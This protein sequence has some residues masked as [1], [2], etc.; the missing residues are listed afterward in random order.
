MAL[1]LLENIE[2][3]MAYPV[4]FN[5]E[6]FKSLPT[7]AQRVKYCREKLGQQLGAGTSRRVYPIDDEKV[8]KLAFNKKGVAQNEAECDWFLQKIGLCAKVYDYDENYLWIEMQKAR[9]AKKSDFKRLCGISYEMMCAYVQYVHSLYSSPKYSQ[10]RDRSYDSEIE[11]ITNSDEYEYSLFYKIYEYMANFQLE[12]YGDLMRLSSWGVV[13][14]DGQEEL[15]LID[16]GL[17]ND[18][19]REFYGMVREAVVKALKE[20]ENYHPI[21]ELYDEHTVF[22]LL[23]E[24]ME[25]KR[26][27]VDRKQWLLIPA[28][29]YTALLERYMSSPTPEMARIPE[30]LVESWFNFIMQ[31]FIDIE[32]ITAL[33]GHSQYFPSDDLEDYFNDVHINWQSYE[34]ASEYLDKI[35]FYDWCL[36]PDGTYAWSDYGLQPI[37]KLIQEYKTTMQPHEILLLINRILNVSHWRGDLAS[38]FIEGGSATCSKISGQTH[39]R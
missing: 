18:V 24:F 23:D 4:A 9:K 37:G 5:M 27:G 15:V 21:Y 12:A 33:A 31:D 29:Q 10:Y 3:E 28:E 11:Q 35:G 2:Q 22:N 26:N 7:F 1:F 16:Y 39:N 14:E 6:T 30:R 38:A 8:L 19:A 20:N 32:N 34:Q 36:F 17:N 25:D 13:I